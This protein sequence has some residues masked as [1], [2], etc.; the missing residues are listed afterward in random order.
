LW[1]GKAAVLGLSPGF[2]DDL[3]KIS[4]IHQI[5]LCFQTMW[6]ASS[7]QKLENQPSQN[8]PFHSIYKASSGFRAH[9]LLLSH[10]F[11]ISSNFSKPNLTSTIYNFPL[12]ILQPNSLKFSSSKFWQLA[13]E[14]KKLFQQEILILILDFFCFILV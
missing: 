10:N 14:K 9:S 1:S 3:C 11:S 2:I 5:F 6:T 13:Y 8:S 12:F 4:S 7:L